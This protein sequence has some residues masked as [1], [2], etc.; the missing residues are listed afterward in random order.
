MTAEEIEAEIQAYRVAFGRQVG[1]EAV[2]GL[3]GRQNNAT[4]AG[5]GRFEKPAP[6][7][8][9]FPPKPHES[10]ISR[11]TGADVPL[12]GLAFGARLPHVPCRYGRPAGAGP[13]LRAT[14]V[15]SLRR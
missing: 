11:K 8:R 3:R 4:E 14:N 9:A 12:T 6:D 13:T 7:A 15:R 1:N 2:R 10:L 5:A